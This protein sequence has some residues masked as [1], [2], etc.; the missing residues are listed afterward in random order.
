MQGQFWGH[1][2]GSPTI[3]GDK[4]DHVL[5]ASDVDFSYINIDAGGYIPL[6]YPSLLATLTMPNF[7]TVLV[8]QDEYISMN[9]DRYGVV[10][11]GSGDNT[12]AFYRAERDAADQRKPLYLPSGDKFRFR[13]T[14]DVGQTKEGEGAGTPKGVRAVY[15]AGSDHGSGAEGTNYI[16]DPEEGF[17]GV[18]F[19]RILSGMTAAGRLHGFTVTGPLDTKRDAPEQFVQNMDALGVLVGGSGEPRLDAF[20]PGPGG[21]YLAPSQQ[22]NL[23]DVA[24]TGVK[25]GLMVDGS[26]NN[27]IWSSFYKNLF[28]IFILDNEGGCGAAFG[29]ASGLFAAYLLHNGTNNKPFHLPGVMTTLGRRSPGGKGG[30]TNMRF[31]RHHARESA[32]AM[33]QLRA[34]ENTAQCSGVGFTGEAF[35]LEGMGNG[36]IFTD[37]KAK[38]EVVNWT[39][40]GFAPSPGKSG[41]P[42]FA[43]MPTVR[44]GSFTAFNVKDTNKRIKPMPNGNGLTLEAVS[45]DINR[46]QGLPLNEVSIQ[47]QTDELEPL[48]DVDTSD[49]W[50]ALDDLLETSDP[51]NPDPDPDPDMEDAKRL[52]E[53]AKILNAQI[54]DSSDDL[55]EKLG[56][57]E[58]A[59]DLG[60]PGGDGGDGGTDPDPPVPP[61][62]DIP[63]YEAPDEPMPRSGQFPAPID[64]LSA[65]YNE[66]VERPRGLYVVEGVGSNQMPPEHYERFKAASRIIEERLKMDIA[67]MLGLGMSN[68]TASFCG[69]RARVLTE[70]D[71][72]ALMPKWFND[73]DRNPKVLFANGA[74]GG[75]STDE[76]D[77]EVDEWDT[78]PDQEWDR[79]IAETL[80]E[81]GY[82]PEDVFMLT[83]T[84]VRKRAT[85]RP[86]LPDPE[87][88]AYEVINSTINMLEEAVGRLPNLQIAYL[89]GRT[90][91]GYDAERRSNSPEPWAE[92]TWYALQMLIER[93]L[94]G[95]LDH[96]P[97][98]VAGP[99]IWRE[100][101]KEFYRMKNGEV[102]D[103]IHH[104]PAG[105]DWI[106]DQMLRFYKRQ[107]WFA[108]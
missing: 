79:V 73:P 51:P 19:M 26:H 1:Y 57:L 60:E 83:T 103:P 27:W 29:R 72:E 107:P 101:P 104:A 66:T 36:A 102:K 39:A 38:S 2:S 31:A 35:S 49:A 10:G 89:Y 86:L 99:C 42:F 96:L 18:P 108:R 52:L 94:A 70:C 87:A 32:F 54:V 47:N 62:E 3:A 17:D 20:K 92:Q 105:V 22:V 16:W 59:L 88:D 8:F 7:D 97:V 15:S 4:K 48:P 24:V 67:V 93:Q 33:L 81:Y 28:G 61:D 23:T 90:F 100:F 68:D 14:L 58:A 50:R 12:E 63:E 53:E 76:W 55:R 30:L 37:R 34:T 13:N 75:Q 71:P 56:E 25:Y 41:I 84:M 80:P 64:D 9:D 98:I 82:K 6:V 46:V 43:P 106:T 5:V 78:K 45:G 74:R 85:A 11:G 95:E 77:E 91:A 40:H 21:I 69:R 65:G 44:L